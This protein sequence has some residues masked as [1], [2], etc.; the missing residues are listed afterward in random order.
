LPKATPLCR[1]LPKVTADSCW[2]L[3]PSTRIPWCWALTRCA[4]LPPTWPSGITRIAELGEQF[5]SRATVM[6][7]TPHKVLDFWL[8]DDQAVVDRIG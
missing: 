5:R 4:V 3:Q 7:M 2:A 1:L 6:T 8:E